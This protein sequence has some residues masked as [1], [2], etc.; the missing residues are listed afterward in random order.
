MVN[1]LLSSVHKKSEKGRKISILKNKK[2]RSMRSARNKIVN[3]MSKERFRSVRK[4]SFKQKSKNMKVKWS[5]DVKQIQRSDCNK[6][7]FFKS[8]SVYLK[9]NNYKTEKYIGTLEAKYVDHRR[10]FSGLILSLIKESKEIFRCKVNIRKSRI[11]D[12]RTLSEQ[13]KIPG[14]IRLRLLFNFGHVKWKHKGTCEQ[15]TRT[16]K[17]RGFDLSWLEHR[18][19]IYV[20]RTGN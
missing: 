8:T 9:V 18:Q 6:V 11:E 16:S 4:A 17:T 10:N 15:V 5:P 2:Y 3:N 13:F 14:N 1:T 7:K 19:E 12:I 20:S